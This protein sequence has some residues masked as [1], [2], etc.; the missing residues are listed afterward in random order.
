MEVQIAANGLC[1]GNYTVTAIDNF[2]CST[3][4]YKFWIKWNTS[5]QIQCLVTIIQMQQLMMGAVYICCRT[6]PLANNNANA[7]IDDGS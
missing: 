5:V 4:K 1:A 6:D 3:G 7:C 2:G